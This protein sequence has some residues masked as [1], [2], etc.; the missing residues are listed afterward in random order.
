MPVESTKAM[1]SSTSRSEVRGRPVLLVQVAERLRGLVR[2]SDTIARFG[3]DEFAVLVDDMSA[4]DDG[5]GLA[6]RITESMRTPFELQSEPVHVAASIGI[7]RPELDSADAEQLLRNADLAMYQ[8]KAARAGGH[9]L[10][11]PGMHAGLV[12]RV[13]LE[14]DLRKA[15]TEDQFVVHYQPMVSMQTG[16]ITGVEALVRWQHPERGLI[17]PND[18]IPLAESTGL[19]REIG[20]WVLREA[21]TQAMSWHAAQPDRPPL[22]LSVNLS[23]RQ[24]QQPELPKLIAEVLAETGLPAQQLTLEMTESVLIDNRDETLTTLT[25]LRELGVKLAIDDFGTGYSSL[26]YLHRFPVDVLKID[27]SFVER[28]STG[29]DTALVSTILRLGQTM[30]LE[31]VAEGIE[32]PQELLLL[33]R[34]QG[35]TT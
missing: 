8:A 23:A 6:E 29:G 20:E 11:D 32:R 2:P 28:L 22:K 33:L 1:P 12:E 14:S 4:D 16:L 18:F 19:I 5:T 24:L 17:P 27:R 21:C 7:A 10:Y 26:S 25:A 34:R 30:R 3:G 9:A 31:T 35:C 15:V 13:R